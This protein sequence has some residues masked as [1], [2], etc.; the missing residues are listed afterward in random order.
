MHQISRGISWSQGYP[1]A[2]VGIRRRVRGAPRAL[3]D[4]PEPDLAA[5]NAALVA[6]IVLV[7]FSGL[8]SGLNLGLMS[9]SAEDLNIIIKGSGDPDER[10]WAQKILPLRDRGNLLLCT[11]LLGNT[12]VNAVIAIFLSELTSGL[13]GTLVTTALILIFGEILPQ[14]VCSRHALAIGACTLPIVQVFIVLC[15]PVVRTQ[16]RCC[17]TGCSAAR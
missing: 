2:D 15:Y 8:F 6:A 10:V 1:S 5:R 12:L 9:F 11:L 7:A 14:S 3:E 13:V 4:D 16:S 17:S